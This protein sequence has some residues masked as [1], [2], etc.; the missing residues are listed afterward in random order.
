MPT[1]NRSIASANLFSFTRIRNALRGRGS[2]LGLLIIIVIAIFISPGF[3]TLSNI[4][5]VLVQNM[6][7]GFVA[8]GMT[9]LIITHDF[10]LSVGGI[11]AVASVEFASIAQKYG[12]G[13]AIVIVLLIGGLLGLINGILVAVVGV[14]SFVATLGTGSVFSGLAYELSHNSSIFVLTPGFSE[15]GAGSFLGIPICVLLFVALT[16][17]AILVL[18]LT[19]F[20]RHVYAVGGNPQAAYLTGVRVKTVRIIAFIVVG[21]LAALGGMVFTSQVGVGQANVG[22]LIP[23]ESIAIVVVGGT[24]LAGGEGGVELTIIGLLIL[25]ILQNVIDALALNSSVGL[26][27]QGIVIVLAVAADASNLKRLGKVPRPWNLLRRQGSPPSK[28]I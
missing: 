10:D 20:G 19:V 21:V 13:A 15:L 9:M 24:T 26:I 16:V 28:V 2:L 27:I 4:R 3:L 18:R 14:N 23:L 1:I 6:P 11:Y 22:S 12:V 8:I 5:N 7:V 17:L 25:G